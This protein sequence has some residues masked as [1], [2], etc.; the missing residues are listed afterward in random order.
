VWVGYDDGKSLGGAETGASAALPAWVTFMK[1]ADEKR[2]ASEFP[3]PAGVTTV[4]I[5]THTGALPLPGDPDT[6]EEIFLEGTQ[7]T[8]PDL[9]DAGVASAVDAAA[10][11][12]PQVARER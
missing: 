9:G 5:D 6:M 11:A 8:S 12:M 3:R 1:A 4:V 7:P 10:D 2:P